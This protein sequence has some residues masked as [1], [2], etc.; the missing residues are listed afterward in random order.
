MAFVRLLSIS[1]VE[2]QPELGHQVLVV[3]NYLFFLGVSAFTLDYRTFQ[4][5]ASLLISQF[6]FVCLD[7]NWIIVDTFFFLLVV[8]NWDS[9]QALQNRAKHT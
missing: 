7:D 1:F 9:L 8:L 3:E 5:F 6:N 2:A 4:F